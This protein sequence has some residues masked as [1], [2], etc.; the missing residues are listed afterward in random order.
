MAAHL[1][2]APSLRDLEQTR[3]QSRLGN[4]STPVHSPHHS[5]TSSVSSRTPIHN[6]TIHEYR[7][8][9]NTPV[10][11]EGTPTGRTLRRK[12]AAPSLSGIERAPS[13]S[14]TLS[15]TSS[16]LLRPRQF[17][18]STQHL[19]ASQQPESAIDLPFRSQSADPRVQSGSASSVSIGNFQKVGYFNSRKRLPRPPKIELPLPQLLATVSPAPHSPPYTIPSHRP[20]TS[21]PPQPSA[22]SISSPEV[23]QIQ[24]T[25]TYS[26]FSLSQFP[27][28]PPLVDPSFSPPHDEQPRTP[29]NAISF[30]STAP[31]TPPAT[32]AIIHYRG[33][34]FDLVNPHD[35]LVLHDIVTPSRDFDSSEYLPLRSSSEPFIVS[36]EVRN[37]TG[38][39]LYN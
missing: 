1:H 37:S 8:Q 10:L 12:P 31:A 33:A 36:S 38:L 20:R 26:S 5:V 16:H 27:Q 23:S 15:S 17:S 39:H 24:T 35:S 18:L 30:Y 7:K 13:V 28:P 21:K 9:Q 2:H 29:V 4:P 32:P 34:S 25:P 14:R 11:Q 19:N 3:L 6:L 22:L